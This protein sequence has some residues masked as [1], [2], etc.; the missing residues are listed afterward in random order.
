[1]LTAKQLRILNF[2]GKN[3][4]REYSFKE[5][6][7]SSK[8]KSNSVLQNAIK[9]FLKEELIIERKIGTSKLYMVNHE[10]DKFYSYFDIIIKESLPAAVKKSIDVIKQELNNHTYFYSIVVFGSYATSKQKEASDLD[11]AVFFEKEAQKKAIQAA[12]GSAGDK[13]LLELDGHAITR[14][15]FLEMLKA[16]YANLGKEI[17]RNHLVIHNPCIFYALLKEGIKNGFRL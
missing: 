10:N 9:Q 8:E 4:F 12:L 1:M 14:G 17:A 6:K 3:L 11:V 13:T 15:E 16:D 2:F 7:K 5:L